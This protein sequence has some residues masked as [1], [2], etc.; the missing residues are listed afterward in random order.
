MKLIRFVKAV[1]AASC[2]DGQLLPG[3][4]ALFGG[5]KT[6]KVA[7]QEPLPTPE[8]P[9]IAKAAD[10]ERI[11]RQRR[12]G[13]LATNL[14]SG[15]VESDPDTMRPKLLGGGRSMARGMQA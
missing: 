10:D 5:A 8:D 7:K 11:A 13:L 3:V 14:T 12:M 2:H 4:S 6:P 9:A 1:Y 15:D